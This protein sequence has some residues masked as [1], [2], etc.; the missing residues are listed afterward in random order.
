MIYQVITKSEKF[1]T[2]S[3]E[4]LI[5]KFPEKGIHNRNGSRE[6]LQGQPKL[7]GLLGPMWGGRREGESVIRYETQQV[8]NM[9]SV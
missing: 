3:K 7:K 2:E 5:K 1:E 8:Y 4:E 6:E 9:L